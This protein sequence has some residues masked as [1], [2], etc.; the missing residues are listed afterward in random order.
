MD[1][2]VLVRG[3]ER[4]GDLLRDAQASSMGIGPA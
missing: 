3:F 2:A 1:N 4:F